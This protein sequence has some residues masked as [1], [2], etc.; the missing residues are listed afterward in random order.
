[1]IVLTERFTLR[2]PRLAR[3]PQPQ[4]ASP[5]FSERDALPKDVSPNGYELEHCALR[6]P[7]LAPGGL[8][9]IK[10]W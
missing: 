8:D 9:A 10:R 2:E 1:M 4:G 6:E 5:R 7:R 3:F